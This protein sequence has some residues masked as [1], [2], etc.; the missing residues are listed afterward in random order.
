[1]DQ[2]LCI[3]DQEI[4]HVNDFEILP[5]EEL[6][7]KRKA[8]LC[9]ECRES[10]FFRKRT[11]TGGVAC[12]GAK[13]R[14]GCSRASNQPQANETYSDRGSAIVI[15]FNFGAHQRLGDDE[16]NDFRE[17]DNET[18]QN[19][20]NE[21]KI[22]RR[23]SRLL[24]SLLYNEGFNGSDREIKFNGQSRIVSE[25]F[26]TPQEA[27]NHLGEKKKYGVWG[28]I[29]DAHYLKETLWLNFGG[30]VNDLSIP[31]GKEVAYEFGKRYGINEVEELS[32]VGIL[33]IGW[34]NQAKESEKVFIRFEELKYLSIRKNI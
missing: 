19:E 11:I 22:S 29:S 17:I 16:K 4:K 18:F 1:M 32:G 3:L 28:I 24:K 2:A 6:I 31:V 12:F 9:P 34:I 21:Q 8:L 10:A 25:F 13:H 7:I 30:T 27:L 15:D 5:E 20:S 14:N 26:K 33:V 23:M